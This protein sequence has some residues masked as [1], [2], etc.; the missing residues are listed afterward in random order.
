MLV[1]EDDTARFSCVE[2]RVRVN[3]VRMT[4]ADHPLLSFV[5]SYLDDEIPK[6]EWSW[7]CL[8]ALPI[9]EE[10][11]LADQHDEHVLSNVEIHCHLG[12]VLVETPDC[13]GD[14]G[15]R[16]LSCPTEIFSAHFF[17]CLHQRQPLE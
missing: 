7:S 8:V 2:H 12:I 9:C 16:C 14:S 17:R 10:N 3:A 6:E 15:S 5:F 1:T 11:E 13:S 4:M